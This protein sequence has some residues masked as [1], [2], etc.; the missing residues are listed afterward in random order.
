MRHKLLITILAT[1]VVLS[2]LP[3]PMAY[4]GTTTHTI[5]N[6]G[7]IV[8][9]DMVAEG[10]QNGDQ[11]RVESGAK[12]YIIGHPD[13][14]YKGS[15]IR[16]E[17]GIG[18]E[19]TLRNVNITN[20]EARVPLFISSSSQWCKITLMG[21]NR[22]MAND[23]DCYAALSHSPLIIDGHGS[24]YLDSTGQKSLITTSHLTIAAESRVLA[25]NGI[26][27]S[28]TSPDPQLSVYGKLYVSREAKAIN[29]PNID[30]KEGS[31]VV[32]GK[33]NIDGTLTSSSTF[34]TLELSTGGAPVPVGTKVYL[35]DN[36]NSRFI[37]EAV[38]QE[39]GMLYAYLPQ[40]S[41]I[42]LTMDKGAK[43]T[44]HFEVNHTPQTWVRSFDPVT[45]SPPPMTLDIEGTVL[46][47]EAP[48]TDTDAI[49][50]TKA[51]VCPLDSAGEFLFSNVNLYDHNFIVD[52][53]IA[54][55]RFV[56]G[57]VY[58][59]EQLDDVVTVTLTG[60]EHSI[61]VTW[62]LTPTGLIASSISAFYTTDN[63]A[64]GDR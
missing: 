13:I 44:E 36:D 19:V 3:T 2:S 40:G 46:R 29:Y 22:M 26:A 35:Y 38:I 23:I 54:I 63:P 32:L 33:N 34:C 43:V 15:N 49:L 42:Y 21:V 58:D 16:C 56:M 53:K 31:Y 14:T 7:D 9:F 47:D 11:I 8:V 48:V 52:D 18:T 55:I 6:T 5:A 28:N 39:E 4:A 20:N 30:F 62:D 50:R 57:D 12:A 1:F 59:W 45:P 61:D 41:S 37:T 25:M 10:V 51:K 17:G 64:T 24:L 27:I 60:H